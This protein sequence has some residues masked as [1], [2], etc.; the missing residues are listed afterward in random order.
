MHRKRGFLS[1]AARVARRTAER[2]D[3]NSRSALD[4]AGTVSQAVGLGV[5]L[6][7][8]VKALASFGSAGWGEMVT[9]AG[10]VAGGTAAKHVANSPGR[11]VRERSLY[12]YAEEHLGLSVEEAEN[13]VD[14]YLSEAYTEFLKER[15]PFAPP[16]LNEAEKYMRDRYPQANSQIRSL[17]SFTSYIQTGEVPSLPLPA[18]EPADTNLGVPG[19]PKQAAKPAKKKK[20]RRTTAA[21]EEIEA[22]TA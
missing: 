12:E 4:T 13:T 19:Q 18:A 3:D 9:G 7:G 14:A 22:A 11:A 21:A 17:H 10:M 5:G 15:I 1:R 16:T 20:A 8:A 6:V 2:V